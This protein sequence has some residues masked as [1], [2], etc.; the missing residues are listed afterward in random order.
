M[1]GGGERIVHDLERRTTLIA[2]LM[3]VLRAV[4]AS[5]AIITIVAARLPRV[6]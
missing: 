6:G 1:N 4:I 2:V 5:T 3:I